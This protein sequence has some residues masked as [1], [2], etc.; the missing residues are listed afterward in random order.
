MKARLSMRLLVGAIA[1]MLACQSSWGA[2]Q[3]AQGQDIVE[4]PSMGRVIFAFLLVAAL[5]VGASMLL[6]RFAPQLTRVSQAGSA[7]RVV[8]RATLS[9]GLR[10]HLVEVAGERVLIAE[11]RGGV[12]LLQLDKRS[13]KQDG[14]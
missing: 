8:D 2:Q 12:T 9:A 14:A 1:M 13:A 6:R 4:L 5:A 7:M 11:N 10:V 3:L